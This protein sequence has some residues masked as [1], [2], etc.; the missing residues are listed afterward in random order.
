MEI[1][2]R[3]DENNHEDVRR[4]QR[5]LDALHASLAESLKKSL[6]QTERQMITDAL[7][8]AGGDMKLAA[9]KLEISVTALA[10]VMR[11]H[12]ISPPKK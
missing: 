12:G 2:I 9:Q 1:V 7:K 10:T 8:E 11:R 5:I 4:V 6:Q 3:F